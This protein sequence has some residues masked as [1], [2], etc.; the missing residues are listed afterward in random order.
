[1]KILANDFIIASKCKT[2]YLKLNK[3]SLNIA[4]NDS[5]LKNIINNSCNELLKY[6][7]LENYDNDNL[8]NYF[9][10]I[11]TNISL[12]DF[13]LELLYKRKYI[14]DKDLE[15]LSYL[16]LEINKMVTVW[17]RNKGNNAK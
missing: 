10:N 2:L 9:I 11:K 6:V 4:K 14:G 5:F 12:I 15:N 7:Y 16:L 3:V 13:Y 17:H 1:M 8:N